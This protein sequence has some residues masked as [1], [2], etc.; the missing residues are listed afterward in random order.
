ML[1]DGL[2]RGREGI[3]PRHAP[4][5][6]EDNRMKTTFAAA[7]AFAI[8]AA[9]APAA[10][11]QGAPADGTNVAALLAQAKTPEGKKAFVASSLALT[12]AE[13]KKFWPVYDAYQ[14]K[15]EANNRRYTLAVEDAVMTSKPISDAYAKALAKELTEIEDAEARARK[16]LYS[17][18]VKA[19]PGRKAVRY[20]QI[21]TKLQDGYRYE[22]A[23][24]L[25]LIK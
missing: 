11:A 16:S 18:A 3:R 13:A 4:Y 25:P 23:T 12:D 14:R 6:H 1:K 21:E 19:L 15:L 7:V 10:G 20:L 5:H 9:V 2:A 17:G 22:I 8:A 24:T